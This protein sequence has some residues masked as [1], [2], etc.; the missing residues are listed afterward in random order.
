MGALMRS[1]DW[2]KTPVGAVETWP[3]SLRTAVSMLL[4]SRFPMY[5]AWGPS[6]VQFYND[7]YRPILGST[8]H[9]AAMG[10]GAQD[11]FAESWHIIGPMFEGVRQGTAVGS[12]DWML[13]LDRHG[14]LEECYFTFSYSPIRDERGA[15]GGVLVTVTETTQRVLGERRLR[16]LRDLAAR[17]VARR[18][19]EG[20]R[21]AAQ[22]LEG[23]AFD[24]PFA[25]L[26]RSA[27]GGPSRLVAAAG[28]GTGRV[29][30]EFGDGDELWG[31]AGAEGGA[32][33]V[34]DV[35]ARFGDLPGGAWPEPPECALAL[36]ITRSGGER[37][38]GFLVA[39]LGTRRAFD[40]D[41]R[42]FLSLVADNVAAA[43]G[44]A[45]AFEEE[46]TRAEAL[47]EV[48]RLKTDFFSNV[49]HEFRT[50]LALML[51]P[52][53]DALADAEHPLPAAQRERVELLR[54]NGLRL[55]K[56]V[57]TLLDF[58][59][60][61][62]GRA[63]A[64]FV[65]TDLA[66]LTRDLVGT[67]DSAVASAGLRLALDLP[68][69]PEPVYVDPALW[70]KVV[71]NLLSNAL[72]FTFQGE[73]RVALRWLGDRVEFAVADTGTGVPAHE[74][75][76]IFERFYRVEGARGRSH[77][78]SGIGLALVQEL[79]KLHGGT[80]AMASELGKGSEITVHLPTSSDHLPR[81]QRAA[82][83]LM[84]TGI[85]PASFLAEVSQ[86]NDRPAADADARGRPAPP[87]LPGARV[88]VVDDN[89]E[90][91]GY[92]SRLLSRYWAVEAYGDG[93]QALAAAR[94]SPPDLVL[95]DVMMPGLDG[96]GLVRALRADER[97]RT[98]PVILLSARAGEEAIV[99][100]LESGADEYLVKPFTTNELLARVNAMLTVSKL[101]QDALRAGRAHAEEA[102]RLL[103]AAER[104]ARAREQTLAIVSHDL[105]T[106]LSAIGTATE[107]LRGE[108]GDGAREAGLR[109]PLEAIRRAVAGMTRLVGD[110]LDAASVDAGGLS[111]EPATHP[112]G[113]I[114]LELRETFES[115]AAERKIALVTD[116]APGVP[117]VWCDKRR[118]LQALSNL[119]S[120]A[121]KFTP[122]GGTVR[123]TVDA[124]PGAVR[125]AV[126]NTGRGI[127]PE[128]RPH[129]FDRYWHATRE[130]GSGHGLGLFIAKGIAEGHG[131]RIELERSGASDTVFSIRLPLE[132]AAPGGAP[133]TGLA[134]PG[135]APSPRPPPGASAAP[136]AFLQAGGEMGA[137]M[138]S[139]D[140]SASSLGPPEGW[141]QS[142]RTSVSTMLRSPYPII[143]FWGPELRMLYND[144]FRPILGA[145]H[146]ATMGAR[147]AEALA[148]EWKL[149]G[150]LM[151]RVH[152]TGEPLYVQNGNV[153]FARRPGGLREEAY[154]TWSYNPTIGERGEIAGLF[155]I[156]SETTRQVVGGRR[157]AVL[158]EL[159]IRTALDRRAEDV[160]RSLEAVLAQAG[161]DTPFALLYVVEGERARL[162]SCAGLPPG[163][164]AAPVELAPNEPGPWPL[165][166]VA[167]SGQERLLEG[168][169]TTLGALPGGPWPEPAVRALVLPVPTGSDADT[170]GVLVVGLSPLC[171]L[172]DEYRGFLQLLARQLAAS[173][174]SARAY[175]NE[176][177]RA[178]ELAELDRAKTAF[179]NNVSHEFRT[180]LTL[181]LGP[182]EDALASADKA[183]S[184]EKL[185]V[186]RRNAARLF[187]MVNTLLDFSRMEA[188]RAQATFV[189]TD[190]AAFTTSL[191]SQFDSAATSAGLALD[192]DCPPLPEAV[193]VD[194]DMWEK[195]VLNLLSNAL[196]YTYA[197]R[198]R[199]ALVWEGSG[200]ALTVEDT[201]VGISAEELPRV[202]ERF[203]RARATQGRS[204]EGTGIGLALVNEL[205]KL[206]GGTVVAES[207]LGEGSSFTVRVP[208]GS[209]HLA[210]PRVERTPRPRA[211]AANAA[212]F[213]EEARRWSAE[214]ES[215]AGGGGGAPAGP[216]DAAEAIDARILVVDDNADLRAYVT[217]L[218]ARVFSHVEAATD[219]L[220][221][222]ERVRERPP[223]LV[224]S[225]VMMPRLDGL[226]LVRALRAE[227]D[228]RAIPIILLSARAG[229]DPTVDG[230]AIGADDYLVK[231][232]S[233]RELTARV[234]TQLAMAR[235]RRDAARDARIKEELR[236]E[237]KAR[238]EWLSIVSHELR[239]PL[240]AAALS[241]RAL[242]DAVPAAERRQVAAVERSFGR[243]ARQVEHL[244]DVS[245]LASNRPALALAPVDASALVAEAVDAARDAAARARCPL[246][247]AIASGVRGRYDAQRLRQ[248]IGC[249]LDN[250]FKFGA[251]RPVEV[252]AEQAGGRLV[253]AVVDHGAGVS[254]SAERRVF[255]RFQR[256]APAKNYGG[257]GLGLWVAR[258]IAEAHGGGVELSPTEGG[259]ATFRASLP[260]ET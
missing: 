224:L 110:L 158:R 149:L 190:L 137:L 204:H 205:V 171:A 165:K 166:A 196:K 48:D 185:D 68:D 4:E 254:P 189:P 241:V 15:V 22:A 203:Y 186:V 135:V 91:R 131:G 127:A 257:F 77:E 99:G 31:L 14:Y 164:P 59:R 216:R 115:Q 223:D 73:V 42:A 126:A 193:Y 72:K 256:D 9:P 20:W 125:F 159:S 11:T 172:D 209:A 180:P 13:P 109:G 249:L 174:S 251:G 10:L 2:A 80:V 228:T 84:P 90:M 46:Q 238:D 96:L 45:R 32:R 167:R 136:M 160:F 23:N 198:I 16:T 123:V 240:S 108:L 87:T 5:L 237:V 188:G 76:R 18:E 155:A 27:P 50:P 39:G 181:I 102:G 43:I 56:L 192:I 226:G 98:T 33:L 106:P 30:E 219:G 82:R 85:G 213:A 89:R 86:W 60:I 92:L 65:P 21:G 199:V 207:V 175:E 6:F 161:H 246:G 1:I 259:G 129:V 117:P 178:E 184:G 258:R 214:G 156:A 28:F 231:P 182:V 55:Q 253:I 47:A 154:F 206:H 151:A 62:A 242:I 146:P 187:K 220:D 152:E 88:V 232:F 94:A 245:G 225:D 111:L 176:R 114:L 133:G 145:K 104:A 69:L 150:P 35:R 227:E 26:Y 97:T 34:S 100:G 260:C 148:E 142:L 153:N 255:E 38:Y 130:Q 71:L 215:D 163:S 202:F 29:P 132:R 211:T 143:L 107:L 70:E 197:G 61:E 248:M 210:A 105:R 95:S 144:P 81:E 222:L 44:S 243:L 24:V 177:R 122:V 49:S 250:A 78:G 191:A 218:L 40:D 113:Q 230:L 208:R 83:P 101:R 54:R 37:P 3:Q 162:V 75:P 233:A 244:S 212:A 74:L 138:R 121:L 128:A 124:E 194:P 112:A 236:D 201:G 170:T 79:V 52:A 41:Y 58:A 93:E 63:R 8:K 173:I 168:L 118:L 67:F 12:E 141:P 229:D 53:D 234:R 134:G 169:D 139:I 36:P 195:I 247:V 7:G 119:L 64:S 217:A 157:L 239:T 19:D 235:V 66:A 103:G 17:A 116:V 200:A 221:A 147:G 51:G 120:N 183:L 57:N 140:W 179:F 252:L 25:L